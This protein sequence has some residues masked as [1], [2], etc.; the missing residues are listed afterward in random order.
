MYSVEDLS[1]GLLNPFCTGDQLGRQ[2]LPPDPVEEWM[3]ALMPMWRYSIITL[4]R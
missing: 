3:H 1:Q 4:L 2:N